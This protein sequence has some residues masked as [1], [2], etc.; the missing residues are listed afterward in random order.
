MLLYIFFYIQF[1]FISAHLVDYKKR[2]EIH[3]IKK[4]K[5][6]KENQIYE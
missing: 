1:H 5:T 2:N 4:K 6:Q 3:F